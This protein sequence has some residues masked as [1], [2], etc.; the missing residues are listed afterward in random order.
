MH[1]G[2]ENRFV[3][4]HLRSGTDEIGPR[5]EVGAFLPKIVSRRCVFR[6]CPVLISRSS[7]LSAV[8][9]AAERTEIGNVSGV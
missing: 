7:S 4:H 8:Y 2:N 9:A 6:E 1:S 5:G 3:V